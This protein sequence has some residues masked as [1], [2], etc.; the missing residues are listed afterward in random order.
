M[1]KRFVLLLSLL[2]LAPASAARAQCGELDPV[3][4]GSSFVLVQAPAAGERIA[5]G[6]TVSGCARTRD[7]SVAWRLEGRDG[8]KLGEGVAPGGAEAGAAPF[9]FP[10]AFE[11]TLPERGTLLLFDGASAEAVAKSPAAALALVLAAATPASPPP[12]FA[13]YAGKLPCA[14]CDG[15]ATELELFG[16]L[17]RDPRSFRLVET[18]LAA[19]DGDRRLERT[20]RWEFGIGS[21]ESSSAI[22]IT[23]VPAEGDRRSFVVDGRDLVPLDR[24]GRRSRSAE[25]DRLA[26]QP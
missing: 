6:A 19:R 15:I 4:A 17:E 9:S 16:E 26:R 8:R 13:R 23:L 2:P 25:N 24:E 12:L 1:P 21:V 7:G 20:G 3:L 10:L 18:R 22:V 14:D 11:I 5:S